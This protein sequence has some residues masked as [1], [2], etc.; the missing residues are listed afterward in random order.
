M[1]K[2]DYLMP[3][4]RSVEMRHRTQIL[5]IS[6]GDKGPFNIKT[7]QGRKEQYQYEAI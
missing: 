3:T 2:K 7:P 1:K 6:G 5:D 4:M